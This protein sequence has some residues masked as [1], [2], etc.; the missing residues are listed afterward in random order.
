MTK[1]KILFTAHRMDI[2][3]IE[4]SL[5]SLLHALDP[6]KYDI[7]LALI[8]PGGVF[9]SQLP[10]YVKVSY[11][12]SLERL[13]DFI[14]S[15]GRYTLRNIARGNV[16]HALSTVTRYSMA[17]MEGSLN[18]LI[19]HFIKSEPLPFLDTEYDLAVC[20]PGPSEILDCL[21]AEH[22]KARRK[23]MWIH[24]DIDCVY[25]NRKSALATNGCYD[26]VFCVSRDARD[27]YCRH[28]P[29]FADRVD[30]FYNL[31]DAGAIIASSEEPSDFAPAQAPVL[32]LV[33]VGRLHPAKGLDIALD[34]A[35]LLR[36]SGF[37]FKWHIVGDGACADEL[38]RQCSALGLDSCVTFYGAT[39]NP[40]PYIKGADIYVQPSRHEGYCITLAEA[41]IFGMPIVATDFVGAVEQLSQRDNAVI[42]KADAPSIA[43]A[44]TLAASRPRLGT[45]ADYTPD[46]SKFLALLD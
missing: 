22:V 20:Y 25:H 45:A 1:K 11:I 14:G 30:V 23:A 13:S 7:H 5:L 43:D 9:F 34:A 21:V 12:P 37:R 18:R 19:S 46:L 17:K 40:Y 16:T 41:K 32:N 33:T 31:V 10:P 2:G 6:D 3:G 35:A 42:C 36:D 27:I 39:P 29:A 28:Y 15:K 8:K 38:K 24:F 44:I 4:K 26:K